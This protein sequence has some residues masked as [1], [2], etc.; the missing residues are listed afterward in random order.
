MQKE[1]LMH[2]IIVSRIT[3]ETLKWKRIT[4]LSEVTD[5]NELYKVRFSVAASISSDILDCVRIQEKSGALTKVKSVPKK[6]QKLVIYTQFLVKD[7]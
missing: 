5:S 2:P 4:P 3:N 6:G 1:T 7:A